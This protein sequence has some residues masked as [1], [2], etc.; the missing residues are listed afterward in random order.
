MVSIRARFFR[1]HG[2]NCGAI[3]K[4]GTLPSASNRLPQ[5]QNWSLRNRQADIDNLFARTPKAAESIRALP[6]QDFIIRF[7]KFPHSQPRSPTSPVHP[8]NVVRVILILPSFCLT[9]FIALIVCNAYYKGEESDGQFTH[10]FNDYFSHRSGRDITDG[11]WLLC[12]QLDYFGPGDMTAD[13]QRDLHRRYRNRAE[14]EFPKFQIRVRT[15]AAAM[16]GAWISKSEGLGR[17]L[18][19]NK[20]MILIVPYGIWRA[21]WANGSSQFTRQRIDANA[22]LSSNLCPL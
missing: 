9:F 5:F 17:A 1:P 7:Q 19:P 3:S 8:H 4:P 6:W 2:P 20:R 13:P 11:V 14:L 16:Q 15:H 10:C 18:W 12:A 21:I 22:G